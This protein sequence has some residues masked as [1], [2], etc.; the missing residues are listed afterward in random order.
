MTE[1]SIRLLGPLEVTQNGEPLTGFESDKVRALLTYLV[2]ETELTHRREKLV[3]LFW[4]DWSERAARA[5]L[6]RALTNLRIVIGDH[7]ETPP[8]LNI[9]RQ[10]IQFNTASD[11]WID[12]TEFTKLL[13]FKDTQQQNIS[14]LEEAVDLYR[15]SF[16]EGFSIADST[17]FEEWAL[18]N[19]ERIR[20]Q[21][22]EA[23]QR[24]TDYYEQ[25]GEFENSLH[26]AWQQVEF[27]PWREKTHRQLMRLLYFSGQRGA[28][29]TQYE[30]CR[31]AL[32]DELGVEPAPETIRLYEQIRDGGLTVPPEPPAFLV[33]ER[34]EDAETP[35]FVARKRELERLDTFLS[36]AFGGSGQ[37]VF[38]TGSAGQ[39]KT[40]LVE[41]FGWRAQARYKDLIVVQGNAQAYAGIG[42]P[43]Q[44]FRKALA[45]LTGD[46]EDRWLAGSITS[47][48]ARRL[49]HTLPQASKAL[50]NYGP[51]LIDAFV[52]G[53]ELASRAQLT[54]P[55]GAPWLEQLKE[56]VERS[57]AGA[58]GPPVQQTDLFD[59]YTSVLREVARRAPVLLFLDDLQWADSGSMSLLFQLSRSVSDAR[60]LLVG[61]YRPGEL[62][63][64][65][66]GER[67]P[68]EQVVNE[69]KRLF[70]D[71]IIGLDVAEGREF[72]EAY[73]D[74]QPNRLGTSFRETLYRQARGHPLFTVELL[75]D[76]QESG[77]LVRDKTGFWIEGPNLNWETL[78]PRVE[79]V[80]AERIQR[81]PQPMQDWLRVASVEGEQFTAEVLA[82]LQEIE[83]R[84]VT[85][86]L[87]GELGKKYRL[88][89]AQG[90]QRLD[91][92]HL[93]RYRF[94][95]VLFQNYM[96]QTLDVVERVNLHE[97]VGTA[98]EELAGSQTVEVAVH[99]ARHFEE[100]GITDKAIHYLLE[101]GNRAMRLSANEEA[102]A[103]FTRGLKLLETLPD[104]PQRDKQELTLQINLT[105]PLMASSGYGAPELGRVCARARD[106]S[107]QVE[108]SPQLFPVLWHLG[109][110]YTMQAE[111]R[112][113]L[114]L[115]D[116]LMNLAKRA[117]DPVLIALAH[118]GMGANLLRTGNLQQSQEHLDHMI[119]FYDPQKHHTLAYTY[120]TDPGVVCLSWV[121]WVLWLMGCPDQAMQRSFEVLALT[122]Q[123]DH[124]ISMALAQSVAALLHQLLRDTQTTVE[125]MEAGMQTATEH[126]LPF[127]LSLFTFIRGW[128]LVQE[129]QTEDGLTH[130][131][132]GLTTFQT[133]GS[134]DLRSMMLSQL[135]EALGLAGQ[136]KKGQEVLTEALAFVERTGEC[137]YEAEIY[138]I[139]GELCLEEDNEVEAATNFRKS[140]QVAHHQ[141][142][143]S[144]E[145][146]ATL[147]MSRL[148]MKQ[149]LLD[150]GHEILSLIYD[151]FTE[152]FDTPDLKDAKVLLEELSSS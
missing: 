115:D 55:E 59:Q 117:G 42:D 91:D 145:L 45:M 126:K 53:S 84:E 43:Y 133:I 102:I 14:Q 1:L 25:R 114:A 83:V 61:A 120:G 39:G 24:L 50:V 46:V 32:V 30:V 107:I 40:A 116:Q 149:G 35:A 31:R 106:L 146:R 112:T 48:H 137:F 82:R 87:S 8:F 125:L 81:L 58:A 108:Q 118:W 54:T 109:S 129:G 62:A 12:V 141:G 11:A 26:Y 78:P 101:A 75:R 69:T 72:V 88:V 65:R 2:V 56:I 122:K 77:R 86:Q 99:L 29:L 110:F 64:G 44:P 103:H 5:N 3:G 105:A 79:G 66:D 127:F 95:H 140:I 152:G 100:A 96:Y 76:L 33:H 34:E 52:A 98:L 37:V 131:R 144:W 28:A 93:A 104:G 70:G 73:L 124:P 67:H 89:A 132:K 113:A 17:A 47:D 9:S 15:G 150:E 111:N 128:A 134:E 135:S 16:L 138:R 22:I 74:S 148:L 4:P 36:Q 23:L 94:R 41:E 121:S 92:Q 57:Q 142:A 139:R 51:S 19:R 71:T 20:R 90:I 80:I 85:A 6:R 60:I 123:L 136:A 119:D 38:V 18:L 151:W 21:L 63:L 27:D 130:M 68:L 7:E 49:W 97:A 147:S 143:K 13:E 10:T